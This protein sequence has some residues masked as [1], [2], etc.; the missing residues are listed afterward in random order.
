MTTD[1]DPAA[2]GRAHVSEP[3]RPVTFARRAL[4]ACAGASVTG[5]LAA[6]TDAHFAYHGTGG[7]A[8]RL[9]LL[10]S[11][12]GLV[13]P[14]AVSVGAAVAAAE[15][16][17]FP[18]GLFA[19]FRAMR[20]WPA[21]R[22][23]ASAASLPLS[24]V[25]LGLAAQVARRAFA[26]GA[27][28]IQ[29]GSMAAL[30]AVLLAALV[31]LGAASFGR[32]AARRSRLVVAVAPALA[33]LLLVYGLASGT[34]NGDGGLLGV[35]GVLTREELDLRGVGLV[36]LVALGGA[37]GSFL[38]TALGFWR[39][40]LVALL[41]LALTPYAAT[42]GLSARSVALAVE[43][44]A[45]LAARPLAAFRRLT[46]RDH[47]GASA[48]FG[49]GDCDDRDPARHPGADDV[50][51]NGI[52]EDC[53]GADD[54]P[55]AV[56]EAKAE[57]VSGAA[58]VQKHFPDGL[59]VVL[60]SVDTL[61]ADLGYAG[62]PRPVSPEIDGLAARS[63]V[64]DR[65][66][67]LASYTGKSVGP[68]LLGKYPSET[69]RNFDH[70]DKFEPG[71]TFVQE[72][73]RRIGVRTM[74]AQGH[75]Y[76]RADTGI[77]RGFDASDY[78]AEPAVPQAEGD[79]TVNG[80]KLTDRA[81]A[82]LSQVPAGTTRFYLWVHYVDVHA[83]YVPHPEFDFGS[84][85]RD[86]YD[87]E[88]RFVDHHVGRLL[89]AIAAG[90]RASRTAVILT[91]DHGEAFG[92]HGM[93]RHGR[94]VWE[95][96]VH[97]PLVVFVPGLPPRHVAVRRSAIDLVPTLLELF[98]APKPSG[99]GSDFVSGQSLLPDLLDT[100]HPSPRP[101]L[102]D[103]CEGPYN[104]ERQAFIDGS[105][106]LIATRGRPLGLYDLDE[107]P[108]ERHDLLGDAARADPVL[109]RFKAFR[110]SLRTVPAHR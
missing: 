48:W 106:K 66:Y 60:V 10:L 58:F 94:E 41:P 52:D 88:V 89:A 20:S 35:F 44:G 93:V 65:A 40:A 85:S 83:A 77:G 64:F 11:D 16:V 99:E 29:G 55:L 33:L 78:S 24:V 101:V 95:E 38:A 28:P 1:V 23:A 104:E 70:F 4:G 96:L 54:A 53:S 72:R 22:V 87:G 46:D 68:M 56:H 36:A 61:R 107:D 6:A 90:P 21:E 110:R 109:V 49:G 13:A 80:D 42:S 18:D 43:R 47:D 12:V 92:E 86:L 81:V 26:A 17:L 98:G 75:W 8:P 15:R 32:A 51:G 76:F 69:L 100:G 102:V 59:D 91:S 14:V 97:V 30:G 2:L 105:M 71:E 74:T 79:R 108:A 57:G 63:V 31:G 7:S 67:S 82:L 62:N 25:A 45:P 37:S 27:P 3:P 9:P 50:P 103:M 5:L 39:L 73:L 34:T 84:K 19:T